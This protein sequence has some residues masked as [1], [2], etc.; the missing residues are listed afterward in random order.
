MSPSINSSKVLVLTDFYPVGLH[1]TFITPELETLSSLFDSVTIIPTNLESN[2]EEGIRKVPKNVNILTEMWKEAR[3]K[4]SKM[5]KL[6][7]LLTQ[8]RKRL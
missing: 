8:L 7:K 3:K 6:T 1:E 2:I 5:S 4:W